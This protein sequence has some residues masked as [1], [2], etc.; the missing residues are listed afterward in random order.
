MM[1]MI[2]LKGSKDSDENEGRML[3]S[4]SAQSEAI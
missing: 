4:K 1:M 2:L 3:C